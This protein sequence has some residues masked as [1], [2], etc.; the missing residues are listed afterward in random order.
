MKTGPKKIDLLHWHWRV[1]ICSLFI[2]LFSLGGLASSAAAAPKQ[3]NPPTISQ[4]VY[5]QLNSAQQQL[6]AG[7]PDKALLTLDNILT[8]RSSSPYEKAL[9][10]QTSGLIYYQQQKNLLIY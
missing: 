9:A 10:Q 7:A 4:Y 5:K 1:F 6:N 3:Q 8:Q 2:Y